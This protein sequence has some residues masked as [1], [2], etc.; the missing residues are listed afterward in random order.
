MLAHTAIHA[1]AQIQRH[2]VKNDAPGTRYRV[3]SVLLR[4]L[5]P[6]HGTLQV[7]SLI[8]NSEYPLWMGVARPARRGVLYQHTGSIAAAQ[9]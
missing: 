5:H 1:R 2:E 7:R 4:A 3:S 9:L 6:H 8:I